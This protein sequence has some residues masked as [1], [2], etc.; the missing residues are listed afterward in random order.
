MKPQGPFKHDDI[1]LDFEDVIFGERSAT[2]SKE[3]PKVSIPD[4]I[5]E[6][7]Q[8]SMT[9]LADVFKKVGSFEKYSELEKSQKSE[10]SEELPELEKK[11]HRPRKPS[12]KQRPDLH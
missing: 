3:S 12:F 7:P 5:P 6:G 11:K 2:P 10:K 9:P 1:D 4:S 8:R